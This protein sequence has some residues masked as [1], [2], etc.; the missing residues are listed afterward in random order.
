M[1]PG[2]SR[3]PSVVKEEKVK[4]PKQEQFGV[5]VLCPTEALTIPEDSQDAESNC[6]L[7]SIARNHILDQHDVDK[8]ELV[9]QST[10][11]SN[12][13]HFPRSFEVKLNTQGVNTNS[14]MSLLRSSRVK[15]KGEKPPK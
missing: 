15:F 2:P 9:P 8:P 3:R 5:E 1:D 7:F 11:V 12:S 10:E 14:N 6:V 13:K 4:T